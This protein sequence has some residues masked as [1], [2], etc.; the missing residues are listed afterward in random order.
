VAGYHL[1]I[2][3]VV[4]DAGGLATRQNKVQ[5]VRD[6]QKQY[7]PLVLQRFAELKQIEGLHDNLGNLDVASRLVARK[8][9]AD[10]IV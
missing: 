9:A 7:A 4:V 8:A 6:Q 10:G 2:Q 1:P 5:F 3:Q